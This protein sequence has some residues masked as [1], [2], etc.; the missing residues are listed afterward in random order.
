MPRSP[1]VSR[2]LERAG[3]KPE[4]E[5]LPHAVAPLAHEVSPRDAAVN[6]AVLDVLGDVGGSHEQNLYA[7]IAAG[8]RERTLVRPLGTETGVLE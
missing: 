8:E 5:E 6:D 1:S 4:P 2:R 3:P 7:G